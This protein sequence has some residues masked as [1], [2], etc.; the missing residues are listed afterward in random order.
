VPVH[1]TGKRR[2]KCTTQSTLLPITMPSICQFKKITDGL[3]N[4]PLLIWLLTIPPHLKYITTVP[5]NL[6]LITTRVS[7]C[8]SF[9]DINF[10]KGSVATHMR[11]GGICNKYLYANLLEN[12]TVKKLKSRVTALSLVSLFWN[13]VYKEFSN[14]YNVISRRKSKKQSTTSKVTDNVGLVRHRQPRILQ[15]YLLIA[16]FRQICKHGCMAL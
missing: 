11:C 10:P 7:D 12:L 4:K 2:R 8:R 13:T 1:N 9:S 6:S 3:S 16:L 15:C 14:Q 5:W